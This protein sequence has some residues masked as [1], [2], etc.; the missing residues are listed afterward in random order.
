MTA[1]LLIDALKSHFTLQMKVAFVGTGRSTREAWDDATTL[2]VWTI[3]RMNRAGRVYVTTDPLDQRTG[4]Q[5]LEQVNDSVD[6][7]YFHLRENPFV[8]RRGHDDGKPAVSK[9]R[10]RRKRKAP[11]SK[12]PPWMIRF[13]A[14]ST[15]YP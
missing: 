8:L 14:L 5:V 1:P 12:A 13:I 6:W 10:R 2:A 4:F 7:L 9:K 15:N 3:T 11:S